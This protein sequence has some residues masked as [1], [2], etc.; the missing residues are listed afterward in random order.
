MQELSPVIESK[1][2]ESPALN[3]NR[4]HPPRSADHLDDYSDD[5]FRGQGE[6]R[7]QLR[8]GQAAE[9]ARG[10]DT[11]AFSSALAATPQADAVVSLA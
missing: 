8:E 3:R 7:R 1:D 4:Y 9:L 10:R 11:K 2:T 6:L 5:A